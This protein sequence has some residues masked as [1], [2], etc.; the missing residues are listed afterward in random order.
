MEVAL[1][2]K[3]FHWGRAEILALPQSEYRAYIDIILK[4]QQKTP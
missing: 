3:H 4:T 2:A 1:I